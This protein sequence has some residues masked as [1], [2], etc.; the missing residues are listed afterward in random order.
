MKSVDLDKCFNPVVMAGG[1]G[2]RLWPL[3][4]ASF[5]KQYQQLIDNDHEYTML[6]ETYSRLSGFRFG[7]SQLI[8]NQEHR[9][10]AAEQ[11][12][13]INISTEIVL[14]PFETTFK[15]PLKP[16]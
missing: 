9:F 2:S 15:N 12:R 10:L 7:L 3:S 14:E 16:L 4:R 13:S 8:C 1:I 6:Q 5:P 11:C